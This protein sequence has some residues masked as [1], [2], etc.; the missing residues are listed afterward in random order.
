VVKCFIFW[1]EKQ[2]AI[3]ETYGNNTI[4]RITHGFE[5]RTL[6][7]YMYSI[8]PQC[9][10]PKM[11][12]TSNNRHNPN[13]YRSLP[14]TPNACGLEAPKRHGKKHGFLIHLHPSFSY[15]RNFQQQRFAKTRLMLN[16]YAQISCNNDWNNFLLL[17]TKPPL[18]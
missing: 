16:L 13:G 10:S 18:K 5:I 14:V 11:H 15:I 1:R 8:C 3:S 2:S 7:L 9:L 4:L 17:N 6:S 12:P